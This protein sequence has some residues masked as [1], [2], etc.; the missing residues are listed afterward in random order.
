MTTIDFKEIP[1]AHTAMGDQDTFELLARDFLEAIGFRIVE[2]P[3]R[4]S[5][6][7]RDLIVA[8]AVSGSISKHEKLWVVSVKHKAHSGKSVTDLDEPD[9]IGRVRKFKAQ[10]FMAFYSTLPSSGLD[11]T[12]VRIKSDTD[13]YIFDRSR[14]EQLILSR[15]ELQTVFQSYF[16]RSYKKMISERKEAVE[17]WG[18]IEPLNCCYCG[19]DI[20]LSDDAL[21]AIVRDRATHSQDTGRKII[22]V[23][24]ACKGHCDISLD[25]AQ[26][27]DTITG[28]E[29]LSDL[30]IPFI[31]M[32]WVCAF[33]NR[34]KG[35]IDIYTDEAYQK[36]LDFIL[37][38]SQTVMKTT[39]ADQKQRLQAL[40]RIPS[41]L[42][43][44]G[45][46]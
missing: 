12:F 40:Q 8:E 15:P 14:I 34:L 26:P 32:R 18:A 43:G 30:R 44:L 13:V 45:E 21:V 19:R 28:W 4:G 7:G 2:G 9:P 11:D 10:G 17:I 42:G 1:E 46:I 27:D 24:W 33:V 36:H 29:D 3:G 22:N 41:F 37:A 25:H 38:M 16:S 39:A 5:D 35:G 23:Y 20:L 6:R 31:F